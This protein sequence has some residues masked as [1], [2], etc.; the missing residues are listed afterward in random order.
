M[1]YTYRVQ[2]IVIH[3][4]K[5]MPDIQDSLSRVRTV[6]TARGQM[7]I[8]TFEKVNEFPKSKTHIIVEDPRILRG[9]IINYLVP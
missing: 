8:F 3:S 1:T 6:F 9:S 2:L 4:Q 7:I 5:I